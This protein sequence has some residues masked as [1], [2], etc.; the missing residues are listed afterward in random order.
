MINHVMKYWTNIRGKRVERTIYEYPY[1][2]DAFVLFKD[3]EWSCRDKADYSDRLREWDRAKF[4]E[5]CM[6]VWGNTGHGFARRSAADVEKFLRLYYGDD[7]LRLTG[8]EQEC[9]VSSGYPYWIFYY[10]SGDEMGGSYESGNY[11]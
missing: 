1:S 10:K 3:P 7:Q 9:N 2:Y 5:C 6:A 8:I 11:H 4:N